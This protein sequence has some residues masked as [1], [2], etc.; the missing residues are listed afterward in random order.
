MK[1]TILP[2]NAEHGTDSDS[3]RGQSKQEVKETP[4]FVFS[5]P[6]RASLAVPSIQRNAPSVT[7]QNPE[8]EKPGV[9]KPKG[10]DHWN[11]CYEL[12]QD[13]DKGMC[14]TWK[15]EIDNLLLFSGLFSG[16]ITTFVSQSFTWLKPDISNESLVLLER[17]SRQL[18]NEILPPLRMTTHSDASPHIVNINI[19]W[20]LSLTLSLATAFGGIICMQWIQHYQGRVDVDNY[21]DAISLRQIRYDGLIW[22]RVPDL[23][24]TLQFM[25]QASIL[26]FSGGILEL[27]W[28]SD[29]RIAITITVA[30][31]CIFGVIVAGSA[32]PIGQLLFRVKALSRIPQCP[33]KSPASWVYSHVL[34]RILYWASK[35]IKR[36]MAG[37]QALLPVVYAK[38]IKVTAQ[39]SSTIPVLHKNDFQSRMRMITKQRTWAD[40]DFNW[41]QL[42]K[43]ESN[44]DPREPAT[45]ASDDLINALCWIENSSAQNV[46]A[47]YALYHCFTDLHSHTIDRVIS[48]LEMYT[49]NKRNNRIKE[50]DPRPE[51]QKDALLVIY[52]QRHLHVHRSLALPAAQGYSRVLKQASDSEMLE[53]LE[54]PSYLVNLVLSGAEFPCDAAINVITAAG[55]S[56]GKGTIP[57]LH[58]EQ[59]ILF[60][61]VSL[62]VSMEPNLQQQ[63][64]QVI[65]DMFDQ[66]D[67]WIFRQEDIRNEKL[68]IRDRKDACFEALLKLYHFIEDDSQYITPILHALPGD[69]DPDDPTILFLLQCI[70]PIVVKLE[71]YITDRRV[72]NTSWGDLVA[73]VRH[74][75]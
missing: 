53:R 22:W 48:K 72:H 25:L 62:K 70:K 7:E 38:D 52:L 35:A 33:Y 64:Q 34:V 74:I 49:S 68:N 29:T 28:V 51:N 16:V 55:T 67:K 23:F 19:L 32:I 26:L 5:N 42:R 1:N 43:F 69:D 2:S 8:P 30:V 24:S 63:L 12:L 6:S 61:A 60:A 11:H 71:P 17:I 37:G 66:C 58:F 15:S 47:V 21:K 27:L 56:L 13:H 45:R 14:D 10:G 46:D 31:S 50:T 9:P 4:I 18:N 75:Y 57:R 3:N 36:I 40:H 20:F 44:G 54:F 41:L 39:R 59:L 65:Q 73:R